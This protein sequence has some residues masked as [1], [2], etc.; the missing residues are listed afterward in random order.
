MRSS[1][2]SIQRLCILKQMDVVI[3]DLD[4]TLLD[5]ESYSFEEA[6][7]ALTLLNSKRIP[8]VY[9]TSKTRRE[10]VHWRRLTENQHPF[11]VENGGAIV[12][13]PDYFG[14]TVPA[15]V[16]LG[17]SYADLVACLK[18]AAAES[19]CRVRGF[20]DMTVDEVA[21]A[22]GLPA[23]FAVLAKDREFDEPFL[24][25]DNSSAPALL[26][27][28]ER[29]GKRWTRGGRFFHIL[30]ANDKAAAVRILLD[31]YR[32]SDTQVRS[33]GIGDGMNDAAFLNTVDVPVLIRTPWL[34]ELQAL[35]P[36][37]I[38]T[39]LPGPRGWNEAVTRLFA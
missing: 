34:H 1:R 33:I 21:R 2:R 13:P 3:S 30:G 22:C 23:G 36:R 15:A 24:I 5:H 32:R 28:I 29:K 26:A 38:A 27:A 37:G 16:Q 31:I 9:C 6:R 18:G 4:G 19:G 10:S 39:T 17:D 7:P 25:L 8:L 11:I 12:I 20:H 35:V 14:S